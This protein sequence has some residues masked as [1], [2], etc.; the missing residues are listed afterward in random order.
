MRERPAHN[1]M[2]LQEK[3]RKHVIPAMKEKFGYRNDLAVPKIVKVVINVGTGK[4]RDNEKAIED[5][6]KSLASVA[7]QQPVFTL[8]KQ[9]IANF[10][11]RKGMKVGMKVTLRGKRMYDFLGRL[12][13][14]AL[15]RSRDFRGLDEK[16]IDQSGNLAIGIKEHI[17][18]PEIS[19]EEVKTIFGFEVCVATN[20]KNR[21]E[22]T[23]LFRL[24]G[25]PIKK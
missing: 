15:P 8:A 10:K 2:K 3:Y 22:G 18:F 1:N 6:R 21:G 9:S 7:G 11:T 12:I 4:F 5:I 13:D 16:I 25:F 14:F 24:M 17:I 23:E 20:A 19:H